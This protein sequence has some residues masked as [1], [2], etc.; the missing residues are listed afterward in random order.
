MAGPGLSRTMTTF[1]TSSTTVLSTSTAI[2]PTSTPSR[3]PIYP[4]STSDTQTAIQSLAIDIVG[5]LL[6]A[7]GVFLLVLPLW[8]RRNTG[9]T[10]DTGQVELESAARE[11]ETTP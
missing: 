6:S 5:V 4:P 10:P 2:Q 11:N 1:I 7:V 8:R 9:P 3:L